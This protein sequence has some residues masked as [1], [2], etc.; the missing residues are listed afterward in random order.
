MLGFEWSRYYALRAH[1]SQMKRVFAI[2]RRSNS[3]S[4]P[5]RRATQPGSR[6]ISHS[7]NQKTS[8]DGR[9]RRRQR[10][11]SYTIS[12]QPGR[13]VS[14]VDR[15]A[16]RTG[17]SKSGID[18][19]LATASGGQPSRS[20]V[21]R[22]RGHFVYWIMLQEKPCHLPPLSFRCLSRFS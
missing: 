13:G 2:P 5:L 14:P 8:V 22:C 4:R 15:M 20:G 12:A 10:T 16:L 18:Y 6:S 3:V 21:P 11:L 7:S 19:R 9:Y 17:S 1:C